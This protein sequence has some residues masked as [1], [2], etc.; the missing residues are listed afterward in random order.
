MKLCNFLRFD[1]DYKGK[2]LDRGGKLEESIW[3]EFSGDRV[4][5]SSIAASI[6]QG[7]NEVPP[8][9]DNFAVLI[10]DEETFPEGSV[11]SRL[12]KRRERNPLLVRKK[13]SKVLQETGALA[14]EVCGFDFQAFYGGLGQGFAECHHRKPLSLLT[15]SKST[16]LSDLAIVCSNCHRMLHRARP[17]KSVEELSQYLCK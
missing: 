5:L 15:D 2:G 12:H 11:L 7:M 16:R 4:L 10:E 17:W 14:C 3:N 13:K 9:A 6:L 8:P 1:P